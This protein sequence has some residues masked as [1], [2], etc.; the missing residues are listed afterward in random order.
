MEK[1]ISV[2]IKL[3]KLIEENPHDAQA[4]FNRGFLIYSYECDFENCQFQNEDETESEW[5]NIDSDAAIADFDKAIE[6]NP[7]YVQA[8]ALRGN[9]YLDKALYSDY[10][11]GY[12]KAM[13]DFEKALS[14]DENCKEA[15]LGKGIFYNKDNRYDEALACYSKA[16]EIDNEY[17]AAYKMRAG[18]YAVID[19]RENEELRDYTS[20]VE[21]EPDKS[22]YYYKRGRILIEK[23]QYK[24]ALSDLNK[25]IELDRENDFWRYLSRAEVYGRLGDCAAAEKDFRSGIKMAGNNRVSLG[26][27]YS[28]RANFYRGCEQY[29]KAIEDYTKAIDIQTEKAF[30]SLYYFERAM[31]YERIHNTELAIS[32]YEK[33][34][35]LDS[36]GNDSDFKK[37]IRN[38]I[39][40]LKK[41]SDNSFLGKICRWFT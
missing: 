8:Y 29:E 10:E 14:L 27:A 11:E 32:D 38:S 9:T 3:S 15:F 34:I 12:D 41:D 30:I 28:I 23:A 36:G 31:I 22:D 16:I 26:Y 40:Q 20:I 2:Y 4:Y 7:V 25:A 13:S 18:L 39:K 21:L 1:F 6:L 35:E 19:N 17:L 37:A 24:A 5:D 33:L